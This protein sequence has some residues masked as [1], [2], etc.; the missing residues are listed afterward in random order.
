MV[1]SLWKLPTVFPFAEWTER[2]TALV[3]QR[4]RLIFD[5]TVVYSQRSV[6]LAWYE[7]NLSKNTSK[8]SNCSPS[9]FEILTNLVYASGDTA[10][11]QNSRLS[12][13][14]LHGLA[15]STAPHLKLIH[16]TGY[17]VPHQLIAWLCK[18]KTDKIFRFFSIECSRLTYD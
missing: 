13:C 12:P 6:F 2:H 16:S 7:T 11:G 5:P 3:V 18:R 8:L 14:Q 17:Q 15:Y 1:Y 4:L 10:K 9:N